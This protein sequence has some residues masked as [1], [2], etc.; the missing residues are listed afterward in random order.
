[1][2]FISIPH[3]LKENKNLYHNNKEQEKQLLAYSM[4]TFLS[5]RINPEFNY[6]ELRNTFL[7]Q[8][9]PHLKKKIVFKDLRI[10]RF[11]KGTFWYFDIHL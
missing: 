6:S 5:G 10:S 11:G 7:Y 8:L 1:M 2:D 4:E 9:Y 3:H